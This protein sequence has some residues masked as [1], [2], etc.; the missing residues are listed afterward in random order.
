MDD[1]QAG[2]SRDPRYDNNNREN[3]HEKIALSRRNSR[4]NVS[5]NQ[6]R[7]QQQ[8]PNPQ[9]PREAEMEELRS[10]LRAYEA[11]NNNESNQPSRNL[12]P[13]EARNNN[14]S[15]QSPKNLIPAQGD[16]G[17]NH[18]ELSQMKNYLAEVMAVIK[19]YD[20]RLSTQLGLQE[21]PSDRS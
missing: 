19:G 12:V 18:D 7:E 14:E 11:Q 6:G 2:S 4:K 3:M 8:P 1:D 13:Y 20:N 16:M 15:N 10:K 17:R 21:T 5:R 9:D